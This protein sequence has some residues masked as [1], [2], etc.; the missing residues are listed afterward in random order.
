MIISSYLYKISRKVNLSL[1]APS[2]I[3]DNIKELRMIKCKLNG[4][5]KN[6]RKKV[7]RIIDET[8][9]YLIRLNFR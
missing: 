1:N 4:I 7:E 5:P 2:T 3:K 8:I 6:D 9:K